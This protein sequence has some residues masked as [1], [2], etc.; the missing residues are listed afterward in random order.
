MTFLPDNRLYMVRYKECISQLIH[1]IRNFSE[2]DPEIVVN[3]VE[4]L[5]NLAPDLALAEWAEHT[6]GGPWATA[7]DLVGAAEGLLMSDAKVEHVAAADMV[8]RLCHSQA[9]VRWLT[10]AG[11]GLAPRLVELMAGD[12]REVL[13]AA[14][15][16]VHSIVAADPESRV[17]MARERWTVPRL[18]YIMQAQATLTE[19]SRKAALALEAMATVPEN[20]G[21]VEK[22]EPMLAE[23][24]VADNW[25]SDVAAASSCGS[26]AAMRTRS[27]DPPSA[28][29]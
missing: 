7:Q 12:D 1:C 27:C 25:V 5:A 28:A 23:L 29:G 17:S 8:A 18:L 4:A 26:A 21:V 16:A 10:A 6:P 9:N 22:H 11:P 19:V 14:V 15:G 13:E 24:A 3:A 2:E 20:R